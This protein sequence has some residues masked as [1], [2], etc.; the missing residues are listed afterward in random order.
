MSSSLGLAFSCSSRLSAHDHAGR[1]EPALQAVHFAKAFLQ[2]VQSAVGVRHALYGADVGAVRL[3]GEY[4]AGPLLTCHRDRPCR[5]RNGLVIA[6]DMRA[7]EIELLAQE[8]DQQG[9]R[10]DQRV[11]LRSVHRQGD[12]CDFAMSLSSGRAARRGRLRGSASRRPSWCGIA[13]GPR[14]SEDGAVIASA[15]ATAFFTAA[16]SSGEPVRIFAAFFR[17]RAASRPR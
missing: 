10:F 5:R 4:R 9:A 3:D 13:P 2:C 11:H 14:V 12:Y 8:V 6:A 7:G 1:A 15:A 17:P 16:A